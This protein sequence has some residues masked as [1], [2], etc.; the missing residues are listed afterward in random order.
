MANDGFPAED[1]GC[2]GGKSRPARSGT[3]QSLP[4]QRISCDIGRETQRGIPLQEQLE[5]PGK[6]ERLGAFAMRQAGYPNR[7]DCQPCSGIADD[8]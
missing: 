1:R 6:A 3:R 8:D 4:H 5:N 7:F 2:D